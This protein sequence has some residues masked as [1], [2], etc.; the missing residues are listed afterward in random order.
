MLLFVLDPDLSVQST[1]LTFPD[2]LSVSEVLLSCSYGGVTPLEK[3]IR[4]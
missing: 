4:L 2:F 3:E 1:R